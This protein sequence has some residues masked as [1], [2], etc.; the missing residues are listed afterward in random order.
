MN[1]SV[2]LWVFHIVQLTTSNL[3]SI[4]REIPVTAMYINVQPM[5]ALVQ[6]V[7]QLSGSTASNGLTSIQDNTHNSSE[8]SRSICKMCGAEPF[9]NAV[10]LL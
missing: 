9:N 10:V 3:V 2:G 4:I 6:N 7:G 5:S 1:F 8:M